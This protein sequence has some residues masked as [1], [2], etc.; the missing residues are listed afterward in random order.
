[1]KNPNDVF[2]L[3]RYAFNTLNPL[4]EEAKAIEPSI[5]FHLELGF[6]D[7]DSEFQKDNHVNCVSHWGRDGMFFQ[8]WHHQTKSDIDALAKKVRAKVEALQAEAEAEALQPLV[9]AGV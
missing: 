6:A 8:T 9:L 2:W 4:V 1:M 3:A 5:Q 7:A